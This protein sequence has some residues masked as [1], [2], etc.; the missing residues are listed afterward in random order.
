[1]KR[2]IAFTVVFCLACSVCFADGI[3]QAQLIRYNACAATYGAPELDDKQAT[4]NS[5]GFILYPFDS[6]TVAFE[7]TASGDIRTG[8]VY[9]SDESQIADFLLSCSAMVTFLGKVDI[10]AQGVLL[11]QFGYTRAGSDSIPGSIGIDSF[12]LMAYDPYPYFFTY[13]NNDLVTY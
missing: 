4:T 6:F 3:T 7:T 11:S 10:Q 8:Y 2:L 9:A 1:M 13:L 12:K 5:S